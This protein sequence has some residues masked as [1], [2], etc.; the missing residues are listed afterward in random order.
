MILTSGA[1]QK[2]QLV[3]SAAATID[4]EVAG[5]DF[6]APSTFVPYTQQTAITTAATTDILAVRGASVYGNTEFISIANKHASQATDVELLKVGTSITV[7]LG[8]VVTLAA[9]E[10][11]IVNEQGTVFVFGVDGGV[12]MG[13]IAASD[14][15]PGLI[16]LAVQSEM[17]AASSVL[18]AVTPGR[19]KYHPGVAKTI[20]HTTGTATPVADANCTYGCTITDTNVGR[21]TVNFSTAYSAAGSYCVQVNVEVI[22]VTLTAAANMMQGF[23]R[24]GG[25]ASASSCEVNNCDRTATTNVIRDPISWHVCTWGDQA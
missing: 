23:M 19:M 3:T 11:M 22:S 24:F 6:T 2:L 9:G 25:Q 18:V 4:V 13:Q 5:V 16:E 7:R 21:L 1:T 12:R 14:T 17:E 8:K 15:A 20:L 10:W